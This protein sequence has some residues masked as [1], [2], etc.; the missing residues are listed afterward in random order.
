MIFDHIGIAVANLE[1][2]RIGLSQIFQIEAWTSEFVDPINQ[3]SVQFGRD[4]VGICYELVAPNREESPIAQAVKTNR[5][6]L[7]HVAYI[8]HDLAA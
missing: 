6:I 4:Q 5:G 1:S 2:G 7:N 8:V 3:V